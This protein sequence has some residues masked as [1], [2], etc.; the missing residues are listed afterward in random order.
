MCLEANVELT[1]DTLFEKSTAFILGHNFGKM[2]LLKKL[3][4]N[5]KSIFDLFNIYSLCN[6]SSF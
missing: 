2:Y 3:F 6:Y 5:D 4:S 1:E